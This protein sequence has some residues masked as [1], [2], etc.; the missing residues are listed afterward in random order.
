MIPSL[1][2]CLCHAQGIH[3]LLHLVLLTYVTSF[4]CQQHKNPKTMQLNTCK[5]RHVI[6]CMS[7]ITG[8]SSY[9]T[10]AKPICLCYVWIPVN[11]MNLDL[12]SAFMFPSCAGICCR[13]QNG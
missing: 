8:N 7:G 3:K 10:E 2:I 4:F 6:V 13:T 9:G 12:K 1:P 11:V 5:A